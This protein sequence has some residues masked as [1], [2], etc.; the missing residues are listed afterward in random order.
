MTTLRQA[1]LF[2]AAAVMI[3]GAVGWAVYRDGLARLADRGEADLSFAA[4]RVT[5]Q[6]FRYRELAVVLARHPDLKARL[7]GGGDKATAKLVVQN[8]ADMTGAADVAVLDLQGRIVAGSEASSL[9]RK[10]DAPPLG[11]ALSGALG[12]YNEVVFDL[13]GRRRYVSFA[14]PIQD[15]AGTVI[16]AVMTRVSVAQIEDNWPGDA[17]PVFF[18][19]V[20]GRVFIT[21]RSDLVL[22]DRATQMVPHEITRLAHHDIW[23]ID[24]GPYL[25]NRALHLSRDLPILGLR[26]EILVDSSANFAAALLWGWMITGA[27]FVFG[28]VLFLVQQ[29]RSALAARLALEAASNQ[30]L[31]ASVTAR[32]KELTAANIDL[33]QQILER[34]EAEAALKR[35]QE[36]LVQAGKLSALGQMSAGISHELNQPLMAIRSFAENGEAFFDRGKPDI[37]RENLGRISELTRR[38]GRIIQNLRA[39]ARQESGPVSDVDLSGVIDAALEVVAD[40]IT[41]QGVEVTWSR[42]NTPI[43]VRGGEVRLQQV[44][45]NLLSNAVDAMMDTNDPRIEISLRRSDTAVVLSLRDTGPGI[46][47]P[48]RIFDPF[49]STKSVASSEGMGLGLS[50]SYGLVQSFGGAIRGANHPDGGAIFD[51][52]LLAADAAPEPR[53][54]QQ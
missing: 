51:V 33:R 21:N 5:G 48:E 47:D 45:V 12:T 36:D 22:R 19:E 50:I 54:T 9:A 23:R 2:V 34:E 37:A 24:A 46:T 25:P 26:A 6:L 7:T 31:E 4:D 17:P 44:V 3:A 43:I 28:A 27:L 29:N 52:E 49:Y 14:A 8:M 15:E 30:R 42:P 40:K 35:A 11:R 10:P 39:F 32:T 20:G 38:M 53:G 1:A 16:G 13:D 41:R 18:T